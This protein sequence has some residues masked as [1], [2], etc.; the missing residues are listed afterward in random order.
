MP[1]SPQLPQALPLLTRGACPCS[2][3]GSS[4]LGPSASADRASAGSPGPRRSGPE[5]A[6]PSPATSAALPPRR[7]ATAAASRAGLGRSLLHSHL[8]HQKAPGPEGSQWGAGAPQCPRARRR[9]AAQ[10]ADCHGP[11]SRAGLRCEA[12]PALA[13]GSG[14]EG[15]GLGSSKSPVPWGPSEQGRVGPRDT[16]T[17]QMRTRRPRDGELPP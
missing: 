11:L 12:R 3:G 10:H 16:T 13:V 17:A 8:I 9:N 1:N 6:S 5:P 4:R 15:E 7:Q 14:G 2:G